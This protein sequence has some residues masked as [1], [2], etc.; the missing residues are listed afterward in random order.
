MP[1]WGHQDPHA[2]SCPK[3]RWES[4]MHRP[5][6]Y[7]HTQPR[8]PIEHSGRDQPRSGRV[9]VRTTPD[10]SA[11]VGMLGVISRGCLI[12]KH[13][14]KFK[15]ISILT[16]FHLN[17]PITSVSES[18]P[19]DRRNGR[20]IRGV[21]NARKKQVSCRG[22]RHPLYITTSSPTTGTGYPNL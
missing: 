13:D 14:G 7:I 18:L 19:S 17:K 1:G 6:T 2:G 22:T 11:W 5:H 12:F 4:M 8:I 10:P 3:P 15:G 20:A 21:V 16:D 9:R